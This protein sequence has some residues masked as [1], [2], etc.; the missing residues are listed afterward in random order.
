MPSPRNDSD[1]S[2]RIAPPTP[3]VAMTIT[4]GIRFGRTWRP[5]MRTSDAP[6]VRAASM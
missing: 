2:V 6:S 3:I 5:R 4:T 1:A